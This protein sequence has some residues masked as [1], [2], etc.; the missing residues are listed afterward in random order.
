MCRYDIQDYSYI[1]ANEQQCQCRDIYIED[2]TLKLLI[3]ISANF[4]KAAWF[5]SYAQQRS[6]NIVQLFNDSNIVQPVKPIVYSHQKI[7]LNTWT[8][9]GYI[10]IEWCSGCAQ[11]HVCH[12]YT[13]LMYLWGWC[14]YW[15]Q[16]R[17]PRDN[18]K[19]ISLP[20]HAVDL[21]YLITIYPGLLLGSIWKRNCQDYIY[22]NR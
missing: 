2:R 10:W 20:R 8:M 15:C 19:G 22:I 21:T 5:D 9:F 7:I 3:F 13:I 6:Y 12:V 18:F 17:Y 1:R 11:W 4:T 16:Y 14:F